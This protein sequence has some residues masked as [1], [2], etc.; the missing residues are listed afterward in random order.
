MKIAFGVAREA[1]GL[2][3]IRFATTDSVRDEI[4]YANHFVA[5]IGVCNHEAIL[6]HGVEHREAI[7]V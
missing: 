2:E 4:A 5:V 3:Q 6:A 1:E 7:R